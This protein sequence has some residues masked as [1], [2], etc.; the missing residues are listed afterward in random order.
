MAGD[1]GVL[2]SREKKLMEVLSADVTRDASFINIFKGAGPHELLIVT[3]LGTHA[4]TAGPMWVRE[5]WGVP[6][7]QL[8]R[9]RSNRGVFRGYVSDTVELTTTSN[10][11]QMFQMGFNEQTSDHR[12]QREIAEHNAEI[13]AK[14]IARAHDAA[15]PRESASDP[16]LDAT[17]KSLDMTDTGPPVDTES[18][19]DLSPQD[20]ARLAMWIADEF[21]KP[22]YQ[23]VWERRCAF[24]LGLEENKCTQEQWFWLNALPALAAIALGAKEHPMVSTFAG[25]AD[26]GCDPDDPDQVTANAIIASEYFHSDAPNLTLIARARPRTID[27]RVDEPREPPQGGGEPLAPELDPSIDTGGTSAPAGWYPDPA[28]RHEFRYWDGNRWTEHV[29]DRQ[30]VSSDP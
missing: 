16:D 21:A 23:A 29:S 10:S 24:G 13:A 6:H 27:L 17:L 25:L 18:T 7:D 4:V 5:S 2:L 8:Q 30:Q 11:R 20:V 22:N 14:E 28:S 9:V 19:Q 1:N 15:M 26:A 12:A 3:S